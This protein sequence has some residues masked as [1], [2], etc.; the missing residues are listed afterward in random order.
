MGAAAGGVGLRAQRPSAVWIGPTIIFQQ[1][2]GGGAA[3]GAPPGADSAAIA[4]SG[5]PS[6]GRPASFTA[7]RR[8]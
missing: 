6:V 2:G 4:V 3:G 5:C 7:G 8:A 1:L